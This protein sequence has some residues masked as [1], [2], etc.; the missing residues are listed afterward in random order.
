MSMD[1][2]LEPGRSADRGRAIED[3]RSALV[4]NL[5]PWI[6]FDNFLRPVLFD[7]VTQKGED[8]RW[9]IRHCI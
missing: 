9:T 7:F 2:M 8:L 5:L 4:I 3:N 6:F 1:P